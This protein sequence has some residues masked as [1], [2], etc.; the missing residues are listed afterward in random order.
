MNWSKDTRLKIW[1]SIAL[2]LSVLIV[3]ATTIITWTWYQFQNGTDGTYFHYADVALISYTDSF[4]KN[5]LVNLHEQGHHVYAEKLNGSQRHR[6]ENLSKDSE[7]YVRPYAKKSVEEDFADTYAF[8]FECEYKGSPENATGKY[9][10]LDGILD[11]NPR[12]RVEK[13]SLESML[14]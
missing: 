7:E 9:E 1:K 12:M 4:W 5:S 10:Y 8:M 2:S 3:G 14:S 6:W 13:P 11:G